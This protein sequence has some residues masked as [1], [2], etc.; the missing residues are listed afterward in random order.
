[1]SAGQPSSGAGADQFTATLWF[2]SASA[3]ADGSYIEIDLGNVAGDD[4]T[5]FLALANRADGAD[6]G[7]QLRA[8]EP[9][10]D[11]TFPILISW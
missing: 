4:R 2:R 6:G 10:A 7:L 3:S 5:T 8:S 9:N 1:M 11:G